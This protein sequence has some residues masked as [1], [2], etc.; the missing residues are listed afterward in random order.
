MG[1][2]DPTFADRAHVRCVEKL[3]QLPKLLG[4]MCYGASAGAEGEDGYI[5]EEDRTSPIYVKVVRPTGTG[6]TVVDLPGAFTGCLCGLFWGGGRVMCRRDGFVGGLG[7]GCPGGVCQRV[8][9]P[10]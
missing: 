7:G 3:E 6:Y 8:H 9:R 2:S 1:T 10:N 5:G 4:R